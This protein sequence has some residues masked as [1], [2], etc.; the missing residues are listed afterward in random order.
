MYK[1]FNSSLQNFIVKGNTYIPFA[2]DNNDYQ[3]FKKDLQSGATLQDTDGNTMTADQI[4]T[5]LGSL[6]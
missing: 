6:K 3:Q 5:F 1:L 4:T 2:P